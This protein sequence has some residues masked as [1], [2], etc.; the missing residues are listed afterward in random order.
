MTMQE[1]VVVEM[2][3]PSTT[4]KYLGPVRAHDPRSSAGQQRQ[5]DRNR[6]HVA[7]H[8]PCPGK[9]RSPVR[10]DMPAVYGEHRLD[11][12]QESRQAGDLALGQQQEDRQR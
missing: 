2:T 5:N 3:R 10:R 7:E 1:R 12:G 11:G 9:H 8:L 4:V 6:D